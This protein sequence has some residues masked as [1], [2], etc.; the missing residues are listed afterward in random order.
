[1]F[2]GYENTEELTQNLIDAGCS[3]TMI[4][5]FLSCLLQGDKTGS[6][7]RLEERRAELLDEIHKEQSCI[8][9]LDEQLYDLRGQSK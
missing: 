9:F 5:G 3:E 7:C 1:M 2:R 6:L 8:Q 4:T